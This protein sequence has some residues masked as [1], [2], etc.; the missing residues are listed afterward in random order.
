[1]EQSS[2]DDQSGEDQDFDKSSIN[3]RKPQKV[4]RKSSYKKV[5]KP[6]RNNPE[7]GGEKKTRGRKRKIQIEKVDSGPDMNNDASADLDHSQTV[8]RSVQETEQR[9]REQHK[10]GKGNASQPLDQRQ[11]ARHLQNGVLPMPIPIMDTSQI[12]LDQKALR[13]KIK[14]RMQAHGYYNQKTQKREQRVN[15]VYET[16]RLVHLTIKPL[17]E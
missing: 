3:E 10:H 7:T 1:M 9:Q 13:S 6:D 14:L 2:N 4:E 11:M 5:N 12:F 15:S 16:E 8:N 17:I